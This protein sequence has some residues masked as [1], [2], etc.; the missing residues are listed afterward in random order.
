MNTY[1]LTCFLAVAETLSFARAAE[2]LHVTQPAVTQQ[3]KSLEKELNVKLFRRNTRTVRMTM[4]GS[5]FLEDARHIVSLSRRAVKRFEHPYAQEVQLLSLGCHSYTHLF[6][7]PDALRRLS[8][9]YPNLHPRLQV[10]PFQHLYRLLEED[11]VEAVIGFREPDSRKVPGVYRE[12]KKIPIICLCHPDNP[13]S[14]KKALSLNEL[15]QENLVLMDPIKSP[16]NVAHL[17]GQLMGG[18]DPSHFYFCE[19][20]EAM[21]VLVQSGFGISVLPDLFVPPDS[22]LV[23]IPLEGIEPISFGL[24]YK[25]LQGNEPLRAFVRIMK[26]V[27]AQREVSAD[28]E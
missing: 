18:R 7:L 13:L 9:I 3:I 4:A 22:P 14:G 12:L 21:I 11:D 27:F 17:Q 8:L 20:P 19:S 25:S 24:Y 26:E 1:Q 5:A 2:Q 16:V 23:R 28:S 10:V 6:L 15:E